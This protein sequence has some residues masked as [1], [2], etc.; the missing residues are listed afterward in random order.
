MPVLDY[1][2]Y[3]YNAIHRGSSIR[4]F[5]E[6]WL[7]SMKR[8][9]DFHVGWMDMSTYKNMTEQF[10]QRYMWYVSLLI[11]F[12]IVFATIYTAI[13]SMGRLSPHQV[14]KKYT[15]QST[16][17]ALT[18]TGLVTVLLFALLRF[19]L[20]ADFL[21]KGWFSL[22]NVI[23]FQCGKIVIYASYFLLGVYAF[24]H[25]WF[26]KGNNLGSVWIWALSCLVLFC[27]T[28]FVLMKMGGGDLLVFRLA[29]VV[30]Y[31]LLTLS[32]FG[33][34]SI[35]RSCSF[36]SVYN[37]N[38]KS[39]RQF[40]QYVPGPLRYPHDFTFVSLNV[41]GTAGI[42]Q[43]RACFTGD[44]ISQLWNK[45]LHHQALSLCCPYGARMRGRS[46]LC[47]YLRCLHNEGQTFRFERVLLKIAIKPDFREA[48]VSKQCLQFSLY[49]G[50]E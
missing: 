44:S 31:P 40:I 48:G 35:I 41:F 30:F 24:S 19:F 45:P 8:I 11:M 33:F 47:A 49:E 28:M 20:Y 9:V 21:D 14:E 22:G 18:I 17:W 5:G 6:Y 43:I 34:V 27:A 13:K 39:C 50:I 16:M 4:G 7:L 10:Y 38:Q 29:F 12:F 37:D 26:T 1:L 15:T 36:E 2:H 42:S 32:F 25:R 3:W 46:A 23:Q